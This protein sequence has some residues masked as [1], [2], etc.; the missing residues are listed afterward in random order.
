M[1]SMEPEARSI[2]GRP[3][4]MWKSDP[5]RSFMSFRKRLIF[6]M[7]VGVAGREHRMSPHELWSWMIRH[8]SVNLRTISVNRPVRRRCRG[9]GR[10][11]ASGSF[12]PALGVQSPFAANDSRVGRDDVDAYVREAERAHLVPLTRIALAV[13]F[14]RLLPA[15]RDGRPAVELQL[16]RAPVTGHVAFQIAVIPGG[17]LGVEDGAD[18]GGRVRRGR[19]QDCPDSDGGEEGHGPGDWAEG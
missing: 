5:P 10:S 11:G 12:M 19:T 1:V 9:G 15:A 16:R 3:T 13:A 18:F 2:G 14:Q 6:C 8:P 4:V 17:D 7:S